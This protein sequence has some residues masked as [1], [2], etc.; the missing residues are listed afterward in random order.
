MG[1]S[2]LHF[3]LCKGVPMEWTS[4]PLPG[5]NLN[6]IL[7]SENNNLSDPRRVYVLLVQGNVVK[8]KKKRNKGVS[9]L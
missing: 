1:V 5:L 9:Y 2:V 6:L 7:V 8:E 4:P 3:H